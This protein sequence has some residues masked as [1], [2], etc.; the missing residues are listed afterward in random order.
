M[1]NSSLNMR[2]IVPPPVILREPWPLQDSQHWPVAGVSGTMLPRAERWQELLGLKQ[3]S[4][5]EQILQRALVKPIAELASRRG[6]RVRGHLVELSCGLLSGDPTG[7]HAKDCDLAAAAVEFIHAGSLIVDDIEDGSPVRRG[8]PA[9]HLRYPMPIALNAGNWLYFWPFDLFKDLAIAPDQLL[10]IYECCHRTL[11][12]A[13]FGQAIDLGAKID[14]LPQK[15]VA[16]VCVASMQ[17]KTG[18]LMGFAALVGAAVAQAPNGLL[19]ILDDFGRNLGVALQMFDDLG[20]VIGKCEPA[21]RYEDLL[22]SRPSWVWACAVDCEADDYRNFLNAVKRLPDDGQLDAWLAAH[23][24]VERARESARAYLELTF[25]TLK[26]RLDA[27]GVRWSRRA[28]DEMR[29][30]GEEIAVAYE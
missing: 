21:K 3:V 1:K 12:R 19:P 15:E 26:H 20:N 27:S 17:L 7:A 14:V 18:A 13:H 29:D 22:L 5:V 25:D 2:D 28:L 4:A 9:L 24:V 8:H 30:L 6:K 16:E 11:L 23:N 10:Q